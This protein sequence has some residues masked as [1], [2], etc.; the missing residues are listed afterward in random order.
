MGNGGAGAWLGEAVRIRIL[1]RIS[2][3]AS[4]GGISLGAAQ[5][6]LDTSHG[7]QIISSGFVIITG[8]FTSTGR[9]LCWG[10]VAQIISPM[11]YPRIHAVRES[12]SHTLRCGAG[13]QPHCIGLCSLA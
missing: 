12:S 10:K 9:G 4:G 2:Y 6:Q 8:G 13:L 11:S 7:C 3:D 1:Y 5:N